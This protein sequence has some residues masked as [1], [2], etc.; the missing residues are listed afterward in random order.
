MVLSNVGLMS[1]AHLLAAQLA[2]HI[3]GQGLL[4]LHR[5]RGLTHTL[6]A[7]PLWQQ[8]GLIKPERLI[9][10]ASVPVAFHLG[11]CPP[12]F[13]LVADAIEFQGEYETLFGSD[14]AGDG[15]DQHSVDIILS[16]PLH[17]HPA[18]VLIGVLQSFPPETVLVVKNGGQRRALKIERGSVMALQLMS[19]LKGQQLVFQ[20]S[21]PQSKDLLL[22]LMECNRDRW[23]PR[24][25]QESDLPRPVMLTTKSVAALVE[26]LALT[27][28]LYQTG[29]LSGVFYASR[30][31]LVLGPSKDYK[32]LRLALNFLA[33]GGVGWQDLVQLSF[34]RRAGK[35][36]VSYADY[37][38]KDR[39]EREP[40]LAQS[41]MS[42][43]DGLFQGLPILG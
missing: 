43:F 29:N 14:A 1:Q 23:R 6:G 41:M 35:M 37:D 42:F 11:L 16:E 24:N 2:K 26:D 31:L 3:H 12:L 13:R 10:L 27:M 38:I 7:H 4:D 30:S 15:S 20:T 5:E 32:H 18:A 8:T 17:T 39:V 22:L 40:K 36:Y 9:A 19:F 25:T 21:G 28:D 33:P 34:E